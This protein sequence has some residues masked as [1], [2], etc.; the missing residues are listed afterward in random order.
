MR[1]LHQFV[2]TFEPGA[3]GNH[4]LQVQALA[5]DSLRLESLIFAE[6]VDPAFVGRARRH[7]DYGRQVVAR[8]GD[9]L[10]YHVAIGSGV[11]DFVRDRP[12]PLVLDH[13]NITPPEMYERWEPAAA[14]GCAWGRDQFPALAARAVLGLA[15]SEWNEAE[16]RSAGCRATATAPILLDFGTAPPTATTGRDWL[17]VGRLSPNKCQHDVIKAFA[18]YRR[19][20][21]PTARLRLVGGSSS[22]S[23]SAALAGFV[24]ALGL[25]EAVELTGAVSAETLAGHYRAS[26]VFVCLSEHEGFGIPLLEAMAHGVPVVAYSSTAVPATVGDAG[27]VLPAKEPARVAAA[28]RRVLTDQVLRSRLGAAAVRRVEKFGLARSQ[29]RWV[30]LLRGVSVP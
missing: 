1:A 23:Y 25:A 5:R 12:E 13:H 10:M 26:G 6:H 3:V 28:A 16:L 2:P 21:D 8:P 24:G 30:E 7:G 27:V 29:A 14:Y 22:A 9:V 18:A 4:V 19:A 17:F 15:D 11:A 20:Y